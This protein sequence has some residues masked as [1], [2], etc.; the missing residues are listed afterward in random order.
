MPIVSRVG[1]IKV[2]VK[3]GE[4]YS[5]TRFDIKN[6]TSLDGGKILIPENIIWEIKNKR[7]IIGRITDVY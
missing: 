6:N 3:N 2:V 4:G 7:D 5:D 1:K